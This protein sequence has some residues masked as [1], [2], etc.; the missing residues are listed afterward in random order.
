MLD[1]HHLAV[2]KDHLVLRYLLEHGGQLTMRYEEMQEVGREYDGGRGLLGERRATHR[3][4]HNVRIVSPGLRPRG[5][6]GARP[7]SH[8]RQ[9]PPAQR[10]AHRVPR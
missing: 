3:N 4:R 5:Q 1:P 8:L 2:V 6:S 10:M 9:A 7:A